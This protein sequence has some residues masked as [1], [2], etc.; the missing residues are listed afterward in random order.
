MGCSKTSE[1]VKLLKRR[2]IDF[3]QKADVD[4][5]VY[6]ASQV[7]VKVPNLLR[8]YLKKQ[9]DYTWSARGDNPQS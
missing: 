9:F 3:I 1:Q 7:R 8:P 5:I 6:L 4:T 2:L